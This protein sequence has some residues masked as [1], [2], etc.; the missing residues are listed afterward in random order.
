MCSPSGSNNQQGGKGMFQT[1]ENVANNWS[2]QTR[3]CCKPVEAPAG[4]ALSK[5]SCHV[6]ACQSCE[7]AFG[8]NIPPAR[9]TECGMLWSCIP[10]YQG[11]TQL[12]HQGGCEVC[13]P[14][15][16]QLGG[17]PKNCYEVLIEH[18]CDSLGSLVLC[19]HHEGI[20]REMIRHHKDV[21]HHWGL[22]QLHP[23]LYTGVV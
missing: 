1:S 6:P 5:P 9:Y 14:I 16:Q 2:S 12:F 3:C 18:L 23:G 21:L 19:H 15:T 4:A 17:C 10:G 20:P 13:T 7:T 11:S 8:G 22:V